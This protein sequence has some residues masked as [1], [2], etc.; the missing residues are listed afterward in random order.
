MEVVLLEVGSELGWV[1][2]A[3]RIGEIGV[4]MVG[5]SIN[6]NHSINGCN[7]YA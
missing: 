2:G 3:E 4:W 6:I 1:E 7:H 5:V